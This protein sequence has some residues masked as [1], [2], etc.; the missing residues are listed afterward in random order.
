MAPE[1]NPF[2][3]AADTAP[4]A[5]AEA[6]LHQALGILQQAA[7]AQK[8]ELDWQSQHEALRLA[9]RLAR[10]H[11]DVLAPAL[12]AVVSLAAPI[13]DALRSTLSR[14]A[15][16]VFQV[17]LLRRAAAGPDTRCAPPAGA[18]C[19]RTPIRRSSPRGWGR[20]WTASWRRLCRCC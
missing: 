9:R 10:H 4:L 3:S 19:A 18:S 1:V 11:P 14:L 6:A 15:I 17:R 5:N 12:H 13:V 7:L 16:A 20:R 2:G 8:R